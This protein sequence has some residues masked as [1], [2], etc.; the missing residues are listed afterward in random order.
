MPEQVT[1]SVDEEAALQQAPEMPAPVVEKIT[2]EELFLISPCA[3]LDSDIVDSSASSLGEALADKTEAEF[4]R[5]GF[6]VGNLSFLCSQIEPHEVT[7]PPAVSHLPHT[8]PWLLGL[9]N[10]RGGLVPVVDFSVA[11]GIGRDESQKL[12]LLVF[13]QGEEV[14]GL[15]VDGLPSTEILNRYEK[16]SS[17]PPHP[18][19]LTGHVLGAYD[20]KGSLWL[21]LA[22]EGLFET[23]GKRITN[24]LKADF[25]HASPEA[26]GY[27]FA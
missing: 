12:Y 2:D 22:M 11:L 3:A 21:D 14:L 20:H 5:V 8:A 1:N 7:E 19:L 16:L 23:F 27:G 25:S 10:L 9:A 24:R 4:K 6:R 13:G 26:V 17:M 18:E 15:L